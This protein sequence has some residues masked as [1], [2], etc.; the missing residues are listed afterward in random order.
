MR[1]AESRR[2][3]S[4]HCRRR[5]VNSVLARGMCRKTV[6]VASLAARRRRRRPYRSQG[7]A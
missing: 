7:W 6:L 4:R 1:M 5:H 3:F 2:C